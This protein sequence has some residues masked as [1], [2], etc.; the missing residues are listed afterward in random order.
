[1]G[2]NQHTHEKLQRG[3]CVSP[4]LWPQQGAVGQPA[5]GYAVRWGGTPAAPTTAGGVSRGSADDGWWRVTR[6]RWWRGGGEPP[7]HLGRQRLAVPAGSQAQGH[8]VPATR[9][10]LLSRSHRRRPRSSRR[11]RGGVWVPG[12]RPWARRA[13]PKGCL[14]PGGSWGSPGPP[15]CRTSP[16]LHPG[17]HPGACTQGAGRARVAGW[18][19]RCG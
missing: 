13:P 12:A 19:G 17:L 6:Q 9:P 4:A 1:M 14:G 8:S 7:A 11:G 10:R 18:V 16:C 2:A 5:G 15:H 3:G